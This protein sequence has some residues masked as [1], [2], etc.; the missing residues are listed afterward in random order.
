MEFIEKEILSDISFSISN[1]KWSFI[2]FKVPSMFYFTLNFYIIEWILSLY[3]WNS[4]RFS[5]VTGLNCDVR[6]SAKNIRQATQC[7]LI[8]NCLKPTTKQRGWLKS[9]NKHIHFI[10]I[11]FTFYSIT[12]HYSLLTMITSNTFMDDKVKF[13]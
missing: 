2:C 7:Q 8:E 13:K 10:S 9:F 3:P 11:T 12:S 5:N 4:L 6:N 1:C